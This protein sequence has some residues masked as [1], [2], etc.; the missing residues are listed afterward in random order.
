VQQVGEDHEGFFRG[1]SEQVLPKL[2]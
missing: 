2:R 1:W